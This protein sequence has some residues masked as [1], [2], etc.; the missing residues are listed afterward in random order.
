M[1]PARCT[2]ESVYVAFSEYAYSTTD[3]KWVP[4]ATLLSSFTKVSQQ[5]KIYDTL[6]ILVAAF[7]GLKGWKEGKKA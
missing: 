2:T 1:L 5:L 7:L 3:K 6:S 4:K